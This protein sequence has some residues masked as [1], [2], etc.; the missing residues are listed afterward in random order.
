MM[1]NTTQV[2]NIIFDKYLAELSPSELKVILVIVRQ[3]YGWIDRKNGGRKSRDRIS[4]SQFM[5][6]TSL[7]RRVLSKTIKS[8]AEKRL[9]N[10][11]C[12]NGNILEKPQERRGQVALYYSLNMCTKQHQHVHFST[13]TC[14]LS[15]HNKTNYTKL[16]KTKLTEKRERTDKVMSIGELLRQNYRSKLNKL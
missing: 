9:I 1:K 14:A 13:P 6:K 10:I 2:P 15:A 12:R 11:T 3:T 4:Y 5:R 16:N 8:L 7:S